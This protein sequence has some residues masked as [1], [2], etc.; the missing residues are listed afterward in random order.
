L[1]I[2]KLWIMAGGNEQIMT[3]ED[4]KRKIKNRYDEV[5]EN[6][7]RAA[8]RVERDP[9]EVKLVAVGKEQPLKKIQIV[10]E[11]GVYACGESRV[12][13]LLDKEEKMPGEIDWHFVGHLQRNKVKYLARMNN[14]SLIQSLD[15]QRLAAEIDKRAKKNDRIFPVLIQVN[16]ARDENKFGFMPEE[17]LPFL[18]KSDQFDNL[19]FAGLM[20]LVPYYEDSEKARPHFKKLVE[21][22][23]EARSE[24]YELPELSMGMTNDYEVAIEE[25]ATIIRLGRALF[26]PRNY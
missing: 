19:E 20:T 11:L 12:Q 17:L 4:I 6:I 14:C 9:E 5:R 2:P 8:A 23:R 1:S 24:G 22:Q 15:S 25:G 18:Q 21:L 3:A 16:V 13:E 26:G 10:R 7:S